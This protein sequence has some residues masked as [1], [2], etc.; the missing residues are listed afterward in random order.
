MT[1]TKLPTKY[2]TELPTKPP[3]V[4]VLFDVPEASFYCGVTFNHAS[5]LCGVACLKG[6]EDCPP[7]LT[8]FGNTP[9]GD[10]NSFFCG[11]SYEDANMQ[12]TEQCPNGSADECP[13][14][15]SC[16]AYTKCKLQT[17]SP[18]E[19]PTFEPTRKATFEPTKRPI[20]DPTSNP[21]KKLSPEVG[22][23]H[24]LYFVI[25][26]ATKTILVFFLADN[27][28]TKYPQGNSISNR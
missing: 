4:P 9:C 7:G 17:E 5:E 28:Y 27:T 11:V 25:L 20:V 1:P 22:G 10:K 15:Q 24:V 23:V 18:I 12:C 6:N 26:L 3:I 14:G 21:S 19:P 16:F 13:S 8:C 2:P